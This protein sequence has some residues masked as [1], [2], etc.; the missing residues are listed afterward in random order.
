MGFAL[1]VFGFGVVGGFLG[2][3]VG[4]ELVYGRVD[5]VVRVGAGVVVVI[6]AA[7]AEEKCC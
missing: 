4:A 7:A 2:G 6:G 5:V 1:H 3:E